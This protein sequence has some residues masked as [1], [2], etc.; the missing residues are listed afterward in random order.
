MARSRPATSGRL[1][2][3]R[4][5][6][7]QDLD[8]VVQRTAL[9]LA[10][11]GA[12][13]M[14]LGLMADARGFWKDASF[15]PSFLSS[16]TS[17]CFGIPIALLFLQYLLRYQEDYMERLRT[18]RLAKAT[19]AELKV[20]VRSYVVNPDALVKA[21]EEAISQG[22]VLHYLLEKVPKLRPLTRLIPSASSTAADEIRDG[23]QNVVDALAAAGNHLEEG[24]GAIET[25]EVDVLEETIEATWKYLDEHIR[26]RASETGLPWLSSAVT[27]QGRSFRWDVSKIPAEHA[28]FPFYVHSSAARQM[29]LFFFRKFLT[30]IFKPWWTLGPATIDESAIEGVSAFS[31]AIYDTS[32]R[33]ITMV[34]FADEVESQLKEIL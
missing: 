5:L 11:I 1:Q 6:F 21:S 12:L 29:N 7:W 13:L 23:L 14:S 10:G 17:A 8:P 31:L 33:L 30:P 9:I 25:R 16:L 20:L 4:R 19:A 27:A 26:L 3:L 15:S 34:E 24:I 18:S 32:R 22:L 2:E 28:D